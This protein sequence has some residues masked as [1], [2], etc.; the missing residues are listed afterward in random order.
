MR[1]K[2]SSAEESRPD[3][4]GRRHRR[5]C[6]SDRRKAPRLATNQT[7]DDENGDLRLGGSS[8]FDDEDQKHDLK[9]PYA[10]DLVGTSSGKEP[11]A[12]IQ[13]QAGD[14]PDSGGEPLNRFAVL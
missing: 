9:R 10:Q 13:E 11:G 2:K 4:L 14:T 7:M 3:A 6:K 12:R 1:T 5:Q 8:R